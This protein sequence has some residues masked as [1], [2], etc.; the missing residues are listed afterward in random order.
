MRNW[1]YFVQLRIA[2]VRPGRRRRSR[3]VQHRRGLLHPGRLNISLPGIEHG[4]AQALVDSTHQT[5]IYSK[6][7]RGN[8][9]VAIKLV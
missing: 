7:T 1:M 8:I 2:A 6:A 4:A 5:C 9:E 3:L